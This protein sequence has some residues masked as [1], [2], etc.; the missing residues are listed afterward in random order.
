MYR[1]ELNGTEVIL[2]EDLKNLIL[3]KVRS[4][5]FGGFIIGNYGYIGQNLGLKF[6]DD[7]AIDI[8]TTNIT[9]DGS[10]AFI[11]AKM[12]Y[13]DQLIF[14]GYL[15]IS[16]YQK[17]DDCS[18]SISLASDKKGDIINSKR[19]IDYAITPNKKITLT[20]KDYSSGGGYEI[21]DFAKFKTVSSGILLN[22]G[23]PLKSD[24]KINGM[25][26][27]SIGNGTFFVSPQD[28]VI[29]LTGIIEWEENSTKDYALI[30]IVKDSVGATISNTSLQSYI[31]TGTPTKRQYQINKT[32]TLLSGY[33]VSMWLYEAT[34][35]TAFEF[36]F[37]SSTFI[38]ITDNPSSSEIPNK[39]D[40]FGVM[41][42]D[43]FGQILS[44]IDNS[45]FFE[46]DF[47]KK[48][49]GK[50][51][52]ITTGNNIRGIFSEINLSLE[53]LIR[54]FGI[55]YDIKADFENNTFNVDKFVDNNSKCG[56][57]NATVSNYSEVADI[58]RL[59]SG[60]KVGFRNWQSESKLKGLEYNSIRTYESQMNFGSRELD[61]VSEFI[62]SGYVI[63]EYRRF[64]FDETEK[65]KEHKLDNS[66]FLI[67]IE[68]DMPESISKY[69]PINNMIISG[70]VY[71][72][73]YSPI[74]ILKN[75]SRRLK[76]IGNL[77]F[78]SGEGNYSVVIN[79]YSENSNLFFGNE[80]PFKVNFEC[81]ID[82]WQFLNLSDVEIF[83]LNIPKFA[84]PKE[85]SLNLQQNGKGLLNFNGE[86]I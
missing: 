29:S 8:I 6:V 40:C 14:N 67:A 49:Q 39:S 4:E 55:I 33:K 57:L 69:N 5:I 46:S 22:I 1:L 56:Y 80:M 79:G 37:L 23:V 85:I 70:G 59:Y 32:L 68:N 7:V 18:V 74:T 3:E 2:P 77:K 58:D 73:K 26:D 82:Y 27:S 52:F 62:T 25:Q 10:L 53:Y 78:A 44:K 48:L 19:L 12:Y 38:S 81:E 51:D 83:A 50:N 20:K 64:Q 34:A 28:S 72:L 60:V 86:L 21:A 9:Q 35:N 16:T 17:N 71:N 61:L 42:F 30:L 75:N 84:R 65:L 13:C 63:E 76:N 41:A 45:I 31:H 36:N 24:S 15:D 43:A 54:E 11:I 66:I 47:F